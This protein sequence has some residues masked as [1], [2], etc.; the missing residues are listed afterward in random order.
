MCSPTTTSGIS[1]RLTGTG[2]LQR[3]HTGTCTSC[4]DNKR[5]LGAGSWA[6][7]SATVTSLPFRTCLPWLPQLQL[8]FKILLPP[9]N[10]LAQQVQRHRYI[11]WE[12]G[13]AGRCPNHPMGA[14][15]LDVCGTEMQ[16]LAFRYIFRL[17]THPKGDCSSNQSH[18]RLLQSVARKAQ[19]LH[20]E[21]CIYLLVG[22]GAIVLGISD[23]VSAE[24]LLAG[25]TL[26][27][28]EV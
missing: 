3:G 9:T 20:A 28:K 25:I 8:Q 5:E 15:G 4:R 21:G 12:D 18:Q 16:I 26:Q 1:P 7:L 24:D 19:Q 2:V 11:L 17:S 23:V 14:G 22:R 10:Q 6:T 27:G 13:M